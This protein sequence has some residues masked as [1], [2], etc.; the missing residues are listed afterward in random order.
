MNRPINRYPHDFLQR[1]L[2]LMAQHIP[3]DTTLNQ[4]RILQ[5]ID[6]R[7]ANDRGHACNTEICA[8]LRMSAATVTRAISSFIEEGFI[9]EEEDPQDGRRRF[10]MMNE[11]YPLRGALNQNVIELA[12]QYFADG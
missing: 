7:S 3:G 8:A 6:L 12:R 2:G 1:Y 10:V 4:I 5:Y 11:S 9:S